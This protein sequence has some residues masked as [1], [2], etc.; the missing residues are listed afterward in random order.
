MVGTPV[1]VTAWAVKYA[2][3]EL[4]VTVTTFAPLRSC[5]PVILLS[6]L[7]TVSWLARAAVNSET[8]LTPTMV[9][10]TAVARPSGRLGS[11]TP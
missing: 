1:K 4:P 2:A 5:T 3:A 8:K 7:R 6:M 9:Q 10:I 11:A